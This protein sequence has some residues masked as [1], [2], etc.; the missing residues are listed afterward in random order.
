M[1]STNDQATRDGPMLP[2]SGLKVFLCHAKQDKPTVRRLSRKLKTDGIQTWFDEEDLL[3]GQQWDFEIKQA[4]KDV[5][6]VLVCLS[7]ASTNKSGYV[8]KEIKFAL[9]AAD[10]QPDGTIFLIPVRLEDCPVPDRLAHLQRVDLFMRN[11]YSRLTNALVRRAEGLRLSQERGNESTPFSPRLL[12]SI[13]NVKLR[14]KVRNDVLGVLRHKDYPLIMS[15]AGEFVVNP[16]WGSIPTSEKDRLISQ[17]NL[18][19]DSPPMIMPLDLFLIRGDDVD[20]HPRL[21]TYF[22][23]KPASG[24]QAYLTPFR[25]RTPGETS[26]SRWHLDESDIAAFLGLAADSVS[27]RN[28]ADKYVVSVKPDPG[29]SGLVLYIFEFSGVTFSE[30]PHWLSEIEFERHLDKKPRRFRWF[31][32]EELELDAAAMRVDA[33]VI[34]GIHQLFS[35]TLQTVPPSVPK[36]FVKISPVQPSGLDSP[37]PLS[38]EDRK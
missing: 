38:E 9:D 1:P 5:D 21:L 7:R 25:K 15:L 32:P 24:W 28:L 23:D 12:R 4:I 27:V 8:Q 29:Y 3:P 17:F 31:H 2:L 26:T 10:E 34:R 33:D 20:G 22:S 13:G 14:K 16:V 36:G 30:P 35:T 19:G 6:V 11:G 37:K 18:N